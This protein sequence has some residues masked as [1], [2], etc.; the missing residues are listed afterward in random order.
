MLTS[1]T[2]RTAGRGARR[3]G[4]KPEPAHHRPILGRL[5]GETSL[6]VPGLTRH[7]LTRR[8]GPVGKKVSHRFA[9]EA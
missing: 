7:G 5:E 6:K 8:I 2:K 9:L 4:T 1:A 3:K